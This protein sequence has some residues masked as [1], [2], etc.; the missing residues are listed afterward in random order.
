MCLIIVLVVKHFYNW[1]IHLHL[2]EFRNSLV[3]ISPFT[4]H[5]ANA[6]TFTSIIPCVFI[7]VFRFRQHTHTPRSYSTR[8]AAQMYNLCLG[9]CYCKQ[10]TYKMAVRLV[11]FSCFV[12]YTFQHILERPSESPGIRRGNECPFQMPL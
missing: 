1:H 11:Q 8:S 12:G 10:V 7:K 9:P 3:T 4:I 6:T 2:I 5:L